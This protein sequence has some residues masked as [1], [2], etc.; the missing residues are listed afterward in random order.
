MF[1][2]N[3]VLCALITLGSAAMPA[4]AEVSININLGVAVTNLGGCAQYRAQYSLATRKE[5]S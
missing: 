2:R 3:T 4:V 1:M 5:S